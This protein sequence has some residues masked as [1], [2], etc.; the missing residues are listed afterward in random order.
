MQASC[1]VEW[2]GNM[3]MYYE[4]VWIWNEVVVANLKVLSHYSP[5]VIEWEDDDKF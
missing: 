3:D 1:S 5:V 4:Y 2:S